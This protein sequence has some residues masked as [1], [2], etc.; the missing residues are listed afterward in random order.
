[1]FDKMRKAVYDYVVSHLD[2]TD[3]VSITLD[4]V[5]IVWSCKTLQNWKACISTTLPDGMY[6]EC[7]YNGDTNELY[8]DAY[9]KFENKVIKDFSTTSV[10]CNYDIVEYYLSFSQALDKLIERENDNTDNNEYGIRIRTWNKAIVIRIQKPDEGSNMTRRYL[11]ENLHYKNY[12][13]E[14]IPWVP[15]NECIFNNFW[16]LVKFVKNENGG[17]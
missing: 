11:Y 10:N 14:N 15:N 13:D 8:L 1:M 9:K 4:D 3:E 7:T 5:Y 16:E 12:K 2:K 6:Y 17:N